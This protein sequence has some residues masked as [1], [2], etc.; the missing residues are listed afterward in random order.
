MPKTPSFMQQLI[1]L[2]AWLCGY[3]PF[4]FECGVCGGQ[5]AGTTAEQ[6]Q[7]KEKYRTVYPGGA[8]HDM[9]RVCD[10]C[11][12]QFMIWAGDGRTG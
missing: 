7:A 5:F 2:W 8:L 9:E 11:Y 1:F 10:P 6:K 4:F 3:E 12:E